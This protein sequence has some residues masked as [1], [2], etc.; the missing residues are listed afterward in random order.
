[1]TTQRFEHIWDAIENDPKVAASLRA[2]ADLMIEIT[3]LIRRQR[4][5]QSQAATMLGVTQPRISNLVHG[6]IDRFSLDM[7]MDMAVAAGLSPRLVLTRGSRKR[8][9]VVGSR[10][11]PG[12]SRPGA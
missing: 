3:E 2:R 7:L 5:T 9:G 12:G 4:M 1:M 10:G 6:K 11:K 8:T